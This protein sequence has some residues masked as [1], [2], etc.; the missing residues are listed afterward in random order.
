MMRILLVSLLV[1]ASAGVFA[2]DLEVAP[3]QELLITPEL[4]HLSVDRLILGDNA[5]VRF[6]DGVDAWQLTAKRAL[7][8]DNVV[9]DGRGAPG[10]AGG[11]GTDVRGQADSCSDG[12]AGGAGEPGGRGGKGV[13]LS[14]SWGIAA[15][16]SLEIL[17]DGGSG[18]A[19]GRGGQG[20]PGGEIS[21]CRGGD[22]GRGGAGG[23]GGDGGNA[24]AITLI[25]WPMGNAV[26]M[27][28]VSRKVS[29]S[30]AGGAPGPG[31]AGGDGG[32]AVEGRYMK[33]S[34]GG[35]KKWLAGGEPGAQGETGAAGAPGQ[36]APVK[37]QQDFGKPGARG[38]AEAA[39]NLPATRNTDTL[40]LQQRV[41]QLE[42]RLQSLEKR[43]Q[44][45]EQGDHHQ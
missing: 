45:L 5:R 32:A 4:A 35:S 25:Y 2:R 37:L 40:S 22:G 29:L 41:Q 6:A 20:Q 1:L 39:R 44:Q 18:G 30:A 13:A 7:I 33:G 27:T 16:G 14:L 24:G 15:L 43:L 21:K 38:A 28:D 8:G 9:I 26:D 34:I 42:A 23:R 11:D 31:G 10:T 36:S 12:R 19:G 3:G 17:S